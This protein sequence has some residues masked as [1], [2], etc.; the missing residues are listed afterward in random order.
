VLVA[1]LAGADPGSSA[2]ASVVFVLARLLHPV[3]YISNLATARSLAFAVGFGCCVWL[4]TLAA[5]A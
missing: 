1:H 4:F 5:Q 3:L 2:I